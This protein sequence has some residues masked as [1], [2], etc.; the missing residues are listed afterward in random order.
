M[1][2]VMNTSD[3]QY[4]SMYLEFLKRQ[5][6]KLITLDD[7][8][9]EYSETIL[10]INDRNCLATENL[11]DLKAYFAK[12][13]QRYKKICQQ[14]VDVPVPNRFTNLHDNILQAL[15]KY[16]QTL[17]ACTNAIDATTNSVCTTVVEK[18]AVRRL[19][20]KTLLAS[21]VWGVHELRACV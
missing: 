1:C 6:S 4:T 3:F 8:F 13:Q 19:R 10:N 20:A 2:V 16:Q 15:E 12:N 18:Q 9:N 5:M 7:V 17:Q 14:L 21:A 11:K